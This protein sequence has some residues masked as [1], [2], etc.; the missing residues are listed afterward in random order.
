[1]EKPTVPQVLNAAC[2]IA[3]AACLTYLVKTHE[4]TPYALG[5]L[6]LYA[7]K[8]PFFAQNPALAGLAKAASDAVAAG[9]SMSVAAEVTPGPAKDDPPTKP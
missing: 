7:M 5:A 6:V 3:V 9:G 4:L 1:M 8:S 2:F